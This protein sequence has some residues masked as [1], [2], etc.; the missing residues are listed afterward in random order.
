M[1]EWQSGGLQGLDAWMRAGMPLLR[2]CKG[3]GAKLSCPCLQQHKRSST[4]LCK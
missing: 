4:Y 3:G 1:A 2:A